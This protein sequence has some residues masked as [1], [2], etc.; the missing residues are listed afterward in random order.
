MSL[1]AVKDLSFSYQGQGE[2]TLSIPHFELNHG[3]RVALIGPNGAGKTTFLQIIALLHKIGNGTILYNSSAI[4]S[5]E[6]ILQYHRQ[7]AFV[8]QRPTMYNRSVL[9]NVA[10]GLMI[11]NIR[12]VEIGER[13]IEMLKALKISH[14]THRNALSISGGE[15]RRVMLARALVLNPK[16]L[17]LDEPFADLDEPVRR[18]IIEDTLPI[19]SST[20]CATIFVTHNQ[21]ETYQLANRFMVLIKGQIVQSGTAYEIFGNPATKEVAEFIGIRNIIP[22]EITGEDSGMLQLSLSGGIHLW[23]SGPAP[24]GKQVLCCIPPESITISTDTLQLHSS[25]RN[26]LQ[27]IIKKVIPSRYLVWLEIDCNGVPLTASVTH[28]SVKELGLT[29]GKPASVL[30]KAT[31]IQLLE[32]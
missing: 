27:G 31:A 11:R 6:D 1:L 30:I 13:V 32:R 22:A 16:I 21:D 2:F 15:A 20:G 18:S 29:S 17:F 10:I 4:K 26:A 3:E 5:R 12:P 28:Q 19:L 24:K 7:T 9:D 8:P 23:Y 14:L 25:A